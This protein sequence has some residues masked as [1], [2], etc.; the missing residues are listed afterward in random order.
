MFRIVTLVDITETRAKRG[1]DPFLVKQQQNYL[2]MLNT[3]G[4]RSNPTIIQ[5]P[6]IIESNEIFGAK[7]KDAKHAWSFIFEIEYGAH[8]VDLLQKDFALVPFIDNLKEDCVFD[9]AVF[10]TESK[11][12]KNIV[13]EEIDKYNT[14]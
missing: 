4:L 11:E 13:F 7:Y 14:E 8:A 9:L 3:I 5:S 2:T 12:T 6:T 10:D 1:E